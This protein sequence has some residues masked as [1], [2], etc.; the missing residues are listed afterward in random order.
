MKMVVP[1]QPGLDEVVKDHDK[2]KSLADAA[3]YAAVKEPAL[4]PFM[5]QKVEERTVLIQELIR[6]NTESGFML[7][8][9]IPHEQ[10]TAHKAIVD[11]AI[12]N[13]DHH[14]ILGKIAEIERVRFL[15]GNHSTLH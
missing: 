15:V 4:S 3:L 6:L 8:P 9:Q 10:V 2:H 14:P 12:S 1:A 5:T 13:P 7:L 11:L